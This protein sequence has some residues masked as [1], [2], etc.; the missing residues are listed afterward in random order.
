MSN[1]DTAGPRNLIHGNSGFLLKILDL[2]KFWVN[3]EIKTK[4]FALSKQSDWKMQCE[5]VDF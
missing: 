5:E 1:Y 2:R 4:I 3:W